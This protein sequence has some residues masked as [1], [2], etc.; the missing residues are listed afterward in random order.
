MNDLLKEAF[1]ELDQIVQEEYGIKYSMKL[2]E[3]SDEDDEKFATPFKRAGSFPA[4]ALRYRKAK[5][6]MNKYISKINRKSNKIISRFISEI[7]KTLP[8]ITKR[9]DNLKAELAQ[10]KKS[11]DKVAAKSIVNQQSKFLE[12]VKKD[13]EA[14]L[15]QL[16]NGFDNLINTYTEAIHRRIDEPGYVLRVELS[17]KG[18]AELKALWDEK[19]AKLR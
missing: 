14:R 18:K 9:G 19:I 16:Q 12:D 3:A 5:N 10:A 4:R 7:D 13:N 15:G 1:E 8:K 11:G 17:D 2:Y 6:V